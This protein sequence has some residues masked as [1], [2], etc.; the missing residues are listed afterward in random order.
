MRRPSAALRTAALV[1]LLAAGTWGCAA[2]PRLPQLP[3]LAAPAAR[4]EATQRDDRVD[5]MDSA[6][7]EAPVTDDVVKSE[8][9]GKVYMPLA[10]VP[11]WLVADHVIRATESDEERS[12]RQTRDWPFFD[13]QRRWAE[14]YVSC[15]TARGYQVAP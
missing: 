5:C 14:A 7:S 9:A 3:D 8:R 4:D 6:Y 2:R 13:W 1:V 15:M 12:R 11:A 10:L